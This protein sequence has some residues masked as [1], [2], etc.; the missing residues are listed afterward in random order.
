MLF[1]SV[2]TQAPEPILMRRVRKLTDGKKRT[3]TIE[4][5]HEDW[6]PFALVADMFDAKDV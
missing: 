4:V 2:G 3:R 5:L 1:V 6:N